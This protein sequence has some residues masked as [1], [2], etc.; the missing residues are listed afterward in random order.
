MQS[1]QVHLQVI[2]FFTFMIKTEGSFLFVYFY[3]DDRYAFCNS[4]FCPFS[5]SRVKMRDLLSL[6]S[7]MTQVLHSFGVMNF[8]I[9]Q[10]IH[11]LKW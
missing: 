9:I 5:F 1:V 6:L 11:L 10:K 2:F 7:G 8:C 3:I 4:Q